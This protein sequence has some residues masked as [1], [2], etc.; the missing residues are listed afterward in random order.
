MIADLRADSVRWRQ[1]QRATGTRGSNSPVM[2]KL[3]GI[4]VPDPFIEPYV[5]SSTYQ[6]S[7]ASRPQR[8]D[9]NSPSVDAGPYG[10]PPSRERMPGGRMPVLERIPVSDRMD[11]DPPPVSQADRRYGHSDRGYQPD[12]RAY[13]SDGRSYPSDGRLSYQP[14]PVMSS[15]HRIPATT[16]YAQDPRYAPS[17]PPP[18]NDGAPPGYVRQGNY[19]VPVSTYETAPAMPPSRSEPPQYAT[20]PY[21]QPPPPSSGREPRDSRYGGQ[22]EY[23]DSREPRYAYPSPAA[24][25][26]SVSARDREPIASPPVP[27]FATSGNSLSSA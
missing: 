3:A 22:P 20:G 12:G 26:T 1:E 9:G 27:R 10:A 23:N 16:G 8:R 21:G 24:T 13:P 15:S 7:S 5:G 6:A 14:E 2:L 11:V 19:Y 4:T 25:V 18:V 17:Y